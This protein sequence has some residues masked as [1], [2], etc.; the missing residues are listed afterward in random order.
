[1]NNKPKKS[2][3]TLQSHNINYVL[4]ILKQEID[5][6]KELCK[7][8]QGRIDDLDNRIEKI[9]KNQGVRRVEIG[10]KI[11]MD[12]VNSG[13]ASKTKEKFTGDSC[14]KEMELDEPDEEMDVCGECFEKLKKQKKKWKNPGRPR[15]F[16]KIE[17]QIKSQFK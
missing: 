7:L 12:V 6:V 4:D 17:E 13:K 5:S 16:P 11:P 14:G 2:N 1:M 8:F 10:F 9:E 3:E 15:K